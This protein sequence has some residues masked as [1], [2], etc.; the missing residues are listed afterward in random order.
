[1]QG[2]LSQQ[3]MAPFRNR[4][5]MGP[6]SFRQMAGDLYGDP[7]MAYELADEFIRPRLSF[8]NFLKN[9]APST[10]VYTAAPKETRSAASQMA[11]DTPQANRA[12]R[13]GLNR[14][15]R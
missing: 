6:V 12:L 5:G 2:R 1:M 14:R 9:E 11:Y 13:W 8:A 10:N 7:T 3:L 4:E 15:Q